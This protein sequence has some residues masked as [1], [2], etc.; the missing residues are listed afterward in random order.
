M[1][2]SSKS[3]RKS[4]RNRVI[5]GRRNRVI[6]RRN[7]K[8]RMTKRNRKGIIREVQEYIR[9]KPSPYAL[10]SMVKQKENDVHRM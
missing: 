6:R 2:R 8:T 1:K 3:I 7:R 9:E 5:R 4:R 10:Q